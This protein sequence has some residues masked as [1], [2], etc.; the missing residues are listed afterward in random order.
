MV[1]MARLSWKGQT[2]PPTCGFLDGKGRPRPLMLALPWCWSD[3]RQGSGRPH[4]RDFHLAPQQDT[5]GQRHLA[6]AV[7]PWGHKTTLYAGAA[8]NKG[9][10]GWKQPPEPPYRES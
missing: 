9:C 10:G 4:A 2:F 6:E 5:S 3:L 1:E 7:I 8:G